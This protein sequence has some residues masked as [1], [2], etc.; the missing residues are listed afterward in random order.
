MA[1]KALLNNN[2]VTLTKLLDGL[3]SCMPLLIIHKCLCGK[4]VIPGALFVQINKVI[5]SLM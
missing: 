5:T 3:K 4:A 2:R 1:S